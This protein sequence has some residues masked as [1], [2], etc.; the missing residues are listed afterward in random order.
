MK[1]LLV[2]PGTQH[3]FHL[4]RQLQRHGCL[5]RFWTGFAY[6]PDGMIGRQIAGL[7]AWAQ[8][9]F[10]GRRLAGLPPEKLRT[11][12][13]TDLR[14]LSRLRAGQDEQRVMFERNADFQRKVPL[15]ELA[16][17]NIII[18]FDTASWLLA[19]KA[20]SL[21]RNFVLDRTTGHPLSFERLVPQLNEQFPQWTEDC[22]HADCLSSAQQK[23]PSTRKRVES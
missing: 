23:M 13:L 17:S 4:A 5:S 12:P 10:A 19:D 21:G 8:R 16:G 20:L 6:D 14:A 1:A 9:R 7:P 18:G 2:H 22:A 3:A 15:S 11:L